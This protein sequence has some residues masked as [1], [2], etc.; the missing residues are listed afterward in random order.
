MKDLDAASFD[1]L[2]RPL[3]KAERLMG[4]SAIARAIG[5]SEDTVRRLAHEPGVPIYRPP[6]L[7]RYVAYRSELEAWLRTKPAP[8]G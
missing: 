5:V 2:T 1:A 4:A 3:K 6:G 8:V 7:G